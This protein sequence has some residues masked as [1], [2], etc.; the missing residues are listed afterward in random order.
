M[1][2]LNKLILFFF[3]IKSSIFFKER[4]LLSISVIEYI[5]VFLLN[6]SSTKVSGLASLFFIDFKI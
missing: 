1:F 6:F 3:S 2:R 5:K 4:N